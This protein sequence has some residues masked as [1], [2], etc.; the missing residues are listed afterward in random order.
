MPSGGLID[1]ASFLSLMN[2]LCLILTHHGLIPGHSK[3][4]NTAGIDREKDK[5]V[6]SCSAL[7]VGQGTVLMHYSCSFLRH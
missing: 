1:M 7:K 5:I 3:T 6:T 4:S 2:M